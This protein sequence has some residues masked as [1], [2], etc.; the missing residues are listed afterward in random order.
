[1]NNNLNINLIFLGPKLQNNK[2]QIKFDIFLKD[3]K[4]RHKFSMTKIAD[5]I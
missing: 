4:H 2:Y 1:M 3:V 5:K